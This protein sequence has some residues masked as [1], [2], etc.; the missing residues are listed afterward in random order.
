M[1]IRDEKNF[2][3][4]PPFIQNTKDIFYQF[5]DTSFHTSCLKNHVLGKRAVEFAEKYI[6]NTRPENRKCIIDKKVITDYNNYIFVDLLTSDNSEE[7]YYFNFIT[8]NKKNLDIWTDRENFVSVAKRFISEGKWG[9]FSSY[10]YL[11]ELIKLILNGSQG[12]TLSTK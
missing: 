10:K 11:D 9:D 6:I 5:S 7:L 4:F 1:K 3:T 2:F 12:I 8:L